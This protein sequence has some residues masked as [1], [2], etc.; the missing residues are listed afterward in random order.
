VVA[1]EA[2]AMAVPIDVAMM[3]QMLSQPRV[4]SNPACAKVAGVS[5][6]A[7]AMTDG[8]IAKHRHSRW[9]SRM[10]R[11]LLALRHNLKWSAFA[12]GQSTAPSNDHNEQRKA[13]VP[14]AWHGR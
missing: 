4:R 5:G 10:Q 14:G 2:M 13:A 3:E 8:A 12:N 11:Q 9:R 7:A 6:C 1:N